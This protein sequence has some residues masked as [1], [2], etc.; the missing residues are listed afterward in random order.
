MATLDSTQIRV[1]VD[2]VQDRGIDESCNG[3]HTREEGT[4]L[5][6][7][8]QQWKLKS[9]NCY[10]KSKAA[11]LVLCWNTLVTIFV[12]YILEYGSVLATVFDY[13]FIIDS[14]VNQL[15]TYAPGFFGA[16]ALLYLL[17]PLAGC[18]S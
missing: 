9:R 13:N 7:T 14:Q 4:P 18:L 17:Y 3:Q 6:K 5:L 2:S 11:I 8:A 1:L 10:V 15:L 12:G 16:L